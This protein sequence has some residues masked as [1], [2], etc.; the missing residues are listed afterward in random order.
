MF[1][2]PTAGSYQPSTRLDNV[3]RWSTRAPL[4]APPPPPPFQ[5]QFN[6][7]KRDRDAAHNQTGAQSQEASWGNGLQDGMSRRFPLYL[8]ELDNARLGGAQGRGQAS[9]MPDFIDPNGHN[10]HYWELDPFP[11]NFSDMATYGSWDP[12]SGG[13][14]DM[15]S[16]QEYG[17]SPEPPQPNHMDSMYRSLPPFGTYERHSGPRQ[18]FTSVEAMASWD[19]DPAER[20]RVLTDLQAQL[21]GTESQTRNEYYGAFTPP[22]EEQEMPTT[23]R[24]YV[25]GFC[26]RHLATSSQ[27]PSQGTQQQ[28][29]PHMHSNGRTAPSRLQR[30][31][32]RGNNARTAPTQQPSQGTQQQRNSHMNNN[33]RTAPVRPTGMFNMGPAPIQQASHSTQYRDPHASSVT[34][35]FPRSRMAHYQTGLP[36]SQPQAF[37]AQPRHSEYDDIRLEHFPLRRRIHPRSGAALWAARTCIG[38]MEKGDGSPRAELE[39]GH[40]YC[41]DC[42]KSKLFFPKY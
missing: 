34:T 7:R 9:E 33:D 22:G 35:P 3:G 17:A 42:F 36:S 13:A 26:N 29:S 8:P 16:R 21:T 39:C 19:A 20:Q 28:R 14:G 27:E 4:P 18:Q 6:P 38:C 24:Q 37:V 2:D 12:A 30:I 5:Q 40:V 15:P 31:F 32:R 41:A 10:S 23:P 1:P 11:D 25:H